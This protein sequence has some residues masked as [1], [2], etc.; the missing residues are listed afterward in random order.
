MG[1]MYFDAQ[2]IEQVNEF[3]KK[4]YNG[5]TVIDFGCGCGRYTECFPA[6]KYIGVDGHEG[7]ISFCKSNWPDRKFEIHDLETW[8]PKKKYDLLFSSVVF[9][10]L[11]NLPVGWA[12]NYILIENGKYTDTFKPQVNDGLKGAE[13]VRLMYV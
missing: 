8:K 9:D 12:K 3:I 11:E 7:N 6:D 5:G 2:P 13:E 10:Q 1:V 4:H